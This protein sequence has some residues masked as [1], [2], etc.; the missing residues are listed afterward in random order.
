MKSTTFLTALASA[1]SLTLR[2]AS[3]ECFKDGASWPNREQARGFAWDACH[4]VNG[5]FTGN[6]E[7]RQ[8]KAMCPDSGSLGL[9]FVV[10]NLN[11]EVGFDLGDDDCSE[12]LN[13]EIFACEHGG[14]STVAGWF[15]R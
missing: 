5:M 10:Q 12:R 15:F 8:L 14:E 3:G 13:N 9:E 1:L 4:S 6:Y 11:T 7:P 2:T